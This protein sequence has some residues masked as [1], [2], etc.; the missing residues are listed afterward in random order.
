MLQDYL[1]QMKSYRSV[2]TI[3]LLSKAKMISLYTS[4]GF[5]VKRLSP[6]IHGEVGQPYNCPCE[7]T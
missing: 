2:D 3:L 7:S 5:T 6:V 4:A 1:R